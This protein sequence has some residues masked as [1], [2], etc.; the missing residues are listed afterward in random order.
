MSRWP[1][2]PSRLPLRLLAEAVCWCACVWT[3]GLLLAPGCVLAQDDGNGPVSEITD[4]DSS[5]NT[6]GGLPN[7][8]FQNDPNLG[9]RYREF[10]RST[11]APFRRSGHAELDSPLT[12]TVNTR[13]GYE[14]DLGRISGDIRIN[15][16]V[17]LGGSEYIGTSMDFMFMRLNYGL[18]ASHGFNLLGRGFEPND[19]DLKAGPFYFQ[20][21]AISGS[22]LMSD[23]VNASETERESGAISIVRLTTSII[24]Q[25][26]ESLRLSASVNLYWLPFKGKVGISTPSESFNFDLRSVGGDRPVAQI[27]WEGRIGGWDVFVIDS[28]YASLTGDVFENYVYEESLFE[29]AGF[30]EFDRA[31]RYTYTGASTQIGRSIDQAGNREEDFDVTDYRNRI[32]VGAQRLLPGPIR[33]Q[34][35][36]YREDLW[37]NQGSRGLPKIREGGSI[38]AGWEREN[39][40]FKPYFRYDI[41]RTDVQPEWDQT[42]ITGLRGPITDQLAMNLYGGTFIEGT[43]DQSSTIGG[44]SLR[45]LAG[46]YTYESFFIG[47][48]VNDTFGRTELVDRISYNIHQVLGPKMFT[49]AFTAYQIARTTDD[50]GDERQEFLAGIRL[51]VL[52]GPRTVARLSYIYDRITTGNPEFIFSGEDRFDD[53][54]SNGDTVFIQQTLRLDLTYRFTESFFGRLSIEH[55]DVDS[56]IEGNSYYE[57]LVILTLTKTL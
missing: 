9:M 37:Y 15:E 22:L 55:R 54:T 19:A 6:E 23:N 30:D 51:I 46:P 57:N 48:E 45:H 41:D 44:L 47:R 33:L 3:L 12:G 39:T 34:I 32:D 35:R 17:P 28:F 18:G 5:A 40:R 50:S 10:F 1:E 4:A 27:D 31:G 20:L 7:D 8:F 43:T 38:F 21:R 11:D 16:R 56:D 49:D 24:A 42:F 14:G 52:P 26:T 25:L 13:T 36:A 53:E 2:G 29:G